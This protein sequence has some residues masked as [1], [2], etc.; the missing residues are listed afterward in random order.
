MIKLTILMRT[1]IRTS[2]GTGS[3]GTDREEVGYPDVSGDLADVMAKD[4]YLNVLVLNGYFDLAT[5]FFGTEY[6]M[7]HLG[8]NVPAA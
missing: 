8:H 2:S 6:T 4:P 3:G 7:D 1:A 5:P